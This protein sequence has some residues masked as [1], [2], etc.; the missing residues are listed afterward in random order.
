MVAPALGRAPE[1]RDRPLVPCTPRFSSSSLSRKYLRQC[2]RNRSPRSSKCRASGGTTPTKANRHHQSRLRWW[3]SSSSSHPLH[4]PLPRPRWPERM[5]PTCSTITVGY[6]FDHWDCILQHKT[7]WSVYIRVH[8]T[9]RV[10]QTV[11]RFGSITHVSCATRS[12]PILVF[13][14]G[15]HCLTETE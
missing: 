3:W 14:L 13:T 1:A 15:V 9:P 5:Q 8:R 7:Q 6:I 4:T 11:F 2:H 12:V 10:T